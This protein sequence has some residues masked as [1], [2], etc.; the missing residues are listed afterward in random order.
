MDFRKRF[1][2]ITVW[3]KGGLR[4]PH[5]LLLALYALG[6]CLRGEGMN[7]ISRKAAKNAKFEV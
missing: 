5:K 1:N 6:R 4:A 2:D 3:K 7:I